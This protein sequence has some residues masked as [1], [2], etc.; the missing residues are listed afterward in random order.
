MPQSEIKQM[1]ETLQACFDGIDSKAGLKVLTDLD[2]EYEQLQFVWS[3]S[4]V[5]M[6][7]GVRAVI[8][9]FMI[10]KR[11]ATIHHRSARFGEYAEDKIK[12]ATYFT[13]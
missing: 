3:A 6:R 2:Y 9:L 12:P 13:K 11:K 1:R 10:T 7:M 5:L 8:D 4:P